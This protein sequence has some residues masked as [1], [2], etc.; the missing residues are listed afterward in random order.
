MKTLVVSDIH[1]NWCALQ[2]VLQAEPDAERILCLGDLVNYG[3]QPVECVGWAMQLSRPHRVI[4]GNH[5]LAF[6]LGCDSN[7]SP[8]DRRLAE[9][10]QSA[11]EQLLTPEMKYYLANLK[12]LQRFGSVDGSCLACHALPSDPLYGVLNS[13][14]ALSLWESE[15]T[16][17]GHPDI[18]FVGHTHIPMMTQFQRTLMVNPGSVGLPR[19]WDPRASYAVWEDHAVSLRRVAYDVTETVRA[20][21]GLNIEESIRQRLAEELKAGG[22]RELSLK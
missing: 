19:D 21:S 14:N 17:A 3:P 6:G 9:A 13:E 12:P 16:T 1:G 4:Q 10:V 11:S 7:C 2:A 20:L 5:D 18:L 22:R 8:A 15:I